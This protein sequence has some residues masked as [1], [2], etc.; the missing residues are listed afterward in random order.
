MQ[1]VTA[2]IIRKVK[3]EKDLL[4]FRHPYAGIQIP[5]GTVEENETQEDAVRREA[6]EE[7]GLTHFCRSVY[8]GFSDEV[9]D[10]NQRILAKPTKVYARP[11]LA[12]FDWAYLRR[13]IR[14][15]V[16]QPGEIFS[17]VRYVEYDQYPNSQYVSMGIIGWVENEKLDREQ[18]RHYYYLEVE[19]KL[20]E[21][22]QRQTDNHT[23]TLF[24]ASLKALPEIVYPQSTWLEQ[25]N[26][27]LKEDQ[28]SEEL[29]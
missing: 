9:V 11:D 25:L 17:Q 15:E 7:T 1:K 4:L 12:S 16:L 22:W 14:L 6:L 27:F 13:G 21:T 28:A 29:K 10:N 26:Y 3:G 24:W 23:F 18:R 8:L 5:A 19:G 2:F 20:K